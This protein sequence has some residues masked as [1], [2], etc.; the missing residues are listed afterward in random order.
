MLPTG[1]A[2]LN[3]PRKEGLFHLVLA[4]LAGLI[5]LQSCF[6]SSLSPMALEG[7]KIAQHA[8]G[9]A[10][11]PGSLANH[12]ETPV[13]LSGFS[14]G[15]VVFVTASLLSGATYTAKM[16]RHWTQSKVLAALGAQGMP[17]LIHS[18]EHL[19]VGSIKFEIDM[20]LSDLPT[21]GEKLHLTIVSNS[22]KVVHG[23]TDA[24]SSILA[25]LQK[26]V[27]RQ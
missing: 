16:K 14:L 18:E 20:L 5:T 15:N 17:S 6:A 26:A 11:P 4:S 23:Q 10:S 9:S 21:D 8:P 7:S 24:L 27:T 19:F 3:S 1:L 2:V 13:A 25:Q 22:T 12:D